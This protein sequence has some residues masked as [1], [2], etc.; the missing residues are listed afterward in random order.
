MY[1]FI[2]ELLTNPLGLPISA[3]YEYVILLILNEIAFKIAWNASPGGR[4]GSEIHW[5]VR[6]PTFII[7]WAITYFLI[8]LAKWIYNNWIIVS[9]IVG[10]I[11]LVAGI[12]IIVI[13]LKKR[14]K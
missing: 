6:I 10:G 9:C 13:S 11:I 8:S 1:R 3:L 2:F 7:L 14:K 4:S 5:A 12:L